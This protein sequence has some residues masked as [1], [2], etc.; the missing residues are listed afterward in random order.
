MSRKTRTH[1]ATYFFFFFFFISSVLAWWLANSLTSC[2]MQTGWLWSL[3]FHWTVGNL[4]TDRK[5]TMWERTGGSATFKA[6]Q[7]LSNLAHFTTVWVDPS[8]NLVVTA[9]VLESSLL[10]LW[11]LSLT[12]SS[13]RIPDEKP[14]SCELREE[15]ACAWLTHEILMPVLSLYIQG[16]I[17]C[18]WNRNSCETPNPHLRPPFELMFSQ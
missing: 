10:S 11:G 6:P 8:L 1:N 15:A 5:E 2:N 4:K 13:W 12:A 9:A 14:D 16:I 18:M 17:I 7:P 3:S